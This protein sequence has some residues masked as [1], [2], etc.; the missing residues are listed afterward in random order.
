MATGLGLSGKLDELVREGAIQPQPVL[1][2]E[3]LPSWLTNLILICLNRQKTRGQ[4]PVPRCTHVVDVFC[5][6]DAPLA[7]A[8]AAAGFT[9]Y[10]FDLAYGWDVLQK[11]NI[12][13]LVS[14]IITLVPGGLLWLGPPCNTWIWMSQSVYNRNAQNKWGGDP[15]NQTAKE[16]NAMGYLVAG[17]MRLATWLGVQFCVEQPSSSRL[18]HFPPFHKA[19]RMTMAN[20]ILFHMAA[21]DEAIGCQKAMKVFSNAEW[22]QNLRRARNYCP[23][24]SS[25]VYRVDLSGVTGG[26]G[27]RGTGH[28][29]M[30]FASY[31]VQQWVASGY[32]VPGTWRNW[33]DM[34]ETSESDEAAQRAFE[35]L[36]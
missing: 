15:A 27:L 4:L 24:T 18:E 20:C 9:A 2:S 21:F 12:V 11:A 30:V 36:R 16:A 14:Y 3:F 23:P 31:L 32:Q 29:P 17:F 25:D 19:V 22:A 26:P 13:Q 1:S 6:Y 33:Q 35:C 28:Y 34:M 7:S 5:G 10:A 8:F